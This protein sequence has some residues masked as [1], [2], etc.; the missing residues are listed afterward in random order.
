[1]ITR[2]KPLKERLESLT[3]KLNKQN[4]MSKLKLFQYAV[5]FHPTE[6]EAKEGK[7]TQLIVK[8]EVILAVDEKAAV[9]QAIRA[10]EPQYAEKSEQTEV[11]VRP[12]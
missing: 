4:N 1:M 8:P 5:L 12:F 9:F 2:K 11:V 3:I 6:A 10:I 7:R